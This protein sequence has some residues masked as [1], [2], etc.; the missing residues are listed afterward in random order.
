[1][2]SSVTKQ[3]FAAVFNTAWTGAVKMATIV[4]SFARAGIYPIDRSAVANSGPATLYS[5]STTTDSSSASS[6][7]C[8]SSISKPKSGST[9]GASS[10]LEAIENI[11]NPSTLQKF[12]ER[13]TEGY[14]V[15]GDELYTVWE[16]L[17]KL[18]LSSGE[19][20]TSAKEKQTSTPVH[21]KD[22]GTTAQAKPVEKEGRQAQ[23]EMSAAFSEI[24][25]YPEPITKK[26]K[27]KKNPMPPHLNSSQMIEYLS[28]KKQDKIDK[29]A[30]TQRKRAEREAKKAEKE[31][32]Q[33]QKKAAR[34]AKKAQAIAA[35]Q[36]KKGATTRGRGKRAPVSK[37]R[38]VME[39]GSFAESESSSTEESDK[40]LDVC[41]VCG[42]TEEDSD[43]GWVAC[44]S[45]SQWYHIACAGIPQELHDEVDSLD[46]Y[47]SKC[48]D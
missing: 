11:M 42:G 48:S 25:V 20:C 43:G 23:A 12:H 45:C 39:D 28:K 47:C 14:N 34:E 1:M 21:E 40:N 22:D 16:Q 24:L 17:K 2:G 41:P 44:D 31:E 33:R 36:R 26:S 46:W 19:D 6:T 10:P 30:E 8:D 35:K 37:G 15:Q 9:S 27:Q 3:S 18:T 4:N 38:P 7:S 32:Q 13:Y 29:E 5:E